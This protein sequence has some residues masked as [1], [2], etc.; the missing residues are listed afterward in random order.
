M[1]EPAAMPARPEVARPGKTPP[2]NVR[3]T[4]T[5]V[6]AAAFV[7]L[8][9]GTLLTYLLWPRWP[10]A[11]PI[12]APA[13]PITIAGTVYNVP[14]G[15]I[16]VPAQRRA[17]AQERID[18]AFHW[19]DLAPAGHPPAPHDE[20]KPLDPAALETPPPDRLFITLATAS[21]ALPPAERLRTIYP[22]YLDT[23]QFEGPDGLAGLRF[24]ADTPYRDEDLFLD[25]AAAADV[26]VARCTRPRGALT[27]S[28]LWER[29][30]GGVDV[31]ARFPRDWLADW[32]R[33]AAAI[34]RV[35]AGLTPP[36][37]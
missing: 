28:C 22:R 21:T 23:G 24:R 20:A 37:H 16:R 35:M 3:L 7:V 34:D 18:L 36:E 12:D 9:A 1:R 30:L 11:V 26:F 29:R 13:L 8:G 19:P 15:A 31:T 17:G 6:I 27:G 25:R 14:P 10:A 33:V 32:R 4:L 2:R 5:V